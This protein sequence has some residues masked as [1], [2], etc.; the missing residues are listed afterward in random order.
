MLRF[1]VFVILCF[2]REIKMNPGSGD[3]TRS[4]LAVPGKF[5]MSL[6]TRNVGFYFLFVKFFI[7]LKFSEIRSSRLQT[8]TNL[9]DA[10]HGFGLRTLQLSKGYFLILFA[11]YFFTFQLH[12]SC[13]EC[14]PMQSV[15]TQGNYVN[16]LDFSQVIP[17]LFKT[18]M[19]LRLAENDV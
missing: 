10:N 11:D 17:N 6:A 3:S 16:L 14:F 2:F 12:T 4:P 15:P 1:F 13:L 18:T 9:P 8:P 7:E 19:L 5:T